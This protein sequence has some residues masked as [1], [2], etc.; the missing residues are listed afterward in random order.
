MRIALY[1][2]KHNLQPSLTDHQALFLAV[3]SCGPFSVQEL[4]PDDEAR[5][6]QRRQVRQRGNSVRNFVRL[7]RG[8]SE[9][10]GTTLATSQVTFWGLLR[11]PRRQGQGQQR[12][13]LLERLF[14]NQVCPILK[15]LMLL[16]ITMK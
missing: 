9:A 10:L 15:F 12:N 16:I 8:S 1:S 3:Q 4:P 14:H 6:R 2:S 13:V 5:Q 11:L 7:L